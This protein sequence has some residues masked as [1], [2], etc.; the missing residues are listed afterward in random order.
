MRRY[1]ISRTSF[2]GSRVNLSTLDPRIATIVQL[3]LGEYAFDV[4]EKQRKMAVTGKGTPRY[5]PEV[6]VPDPVHSL[7]RQTPARIADIL[8]T[9]KLLT[10]KVG[11]DTREMV[12][13][14]NGIR[15]SFLRLLRRVHA[16]EQV[17]P[18]ESKNV[19][20]CYH[21]MS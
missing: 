17:F 8:P 20:R 16:W 9:V 7:L 18:I 12:K 1:T 14:G 3:E 10:P 4:E 5:S 19:R 21:T 15:T 2:E 13:G 6:R 11:M